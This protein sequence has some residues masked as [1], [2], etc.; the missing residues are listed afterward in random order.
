MRKSLVI[1]ATGLLFAGSLASQTT[2]ESAR[3]ALAESLPEVAVARAERFLAANPDLKS[4]EQAEA[5]LFLGESYFRNNQVDEALATLAKVPNS[6]ASTR[7]YWQGM[8]LAHQQNNSQALEKF[9]TVDSEN[10][11]YSSA[12]FNTLEL[13]LSNEDHAPAFELLKKLRAHDPNFL[14]ARLPLLESQLFLS[15][16]EPDNARKALQSLIDGKTPSPECQLLAGRIELAANQPDLALQAFE[17]ALTPETPSKIKAL[18]LLGTCDAYLQA[19]PFERALEPLLRLLKME[20]SEDLLSLIASR[21]EILID[22]SAPEDEVITSLTAFVN[23]SNLG[24]D[25]NLLS[26]QKLLACYYL[27]RI[28]PPDRAK[29]LFQLIVTLAPEGELAARSHLQLSMLAWENGE[30]EEALQSLQ[31]AQKAAPESAIAMG[32]A[33]LAARIKT[34]Q[35]DLAAALPL[36]AQASRHPNPTFS[37]HALLNQAL[38]TLASNPNAPLSAI[39]AQLETEEAKVSLELEQAL[40]LARENNAS[41]RATLQEFLFQHP[42]HPRAPQARLALA[43][44]LLS[45]PQPDFNLIEVQLASLPAHLDDRKLS[46]QRFRVSRK[47]GTI[48]DQWDQA[49]LSGE[50]H[51]ID[52]PEAENDPYFLL[53]LGESS[54]R[55]GDFN[56]SRILF[57]KVTAL[58]DAGELVEL[59]LYFKAISNLAILTEEATATALDTFDSIIQRRRPPRHSRSLGKSANPT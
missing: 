2:L 26:P 45:E 41:A 43:N 56:R 40:S 23:P 51:R 14:P 57:S 1:L 49:V 53:R 32:A 54:Y 20:D 9:S 19:P 4:E 34:Q 21:F 31:D 48:T 28:S 30:S 50:K 27:S 7:N 42:D 5:L 58:P 47:L 25:G 18:A 44:L 24:E 11:L 59:A 35:G 15:M 12:L 29:A 55:K 38:L 16:D 10:T 22:E 36:F 17:K 6:S 39:A 46:R 8:A 33:D 37:E 13:S 3:N 52:F